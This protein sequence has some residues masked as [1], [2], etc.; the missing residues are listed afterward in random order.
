M[1]QQ[2]FHRQAC[3]RAAAAVAAEAVTVVAT[4]MAVVVVVET[5]AAA[6]VQVA[7]VAEVTQV[8]AGAVQAAGFSA[9][10]LG[11]AADGVNIDKKAAL[12]CF[13]AFFTY[14]LGH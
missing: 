1:C 9:D 2:A 13:F 7:A 3:P 11:V 4:A 14:L 8:A 10:N 12:S 6:R 5:S